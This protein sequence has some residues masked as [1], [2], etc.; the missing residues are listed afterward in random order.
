M[1]N[2]MED[3]IKGKPLDVLRSGIATALRFNAPEDVVNKLRLAHVRGVI[4][5]PIQIDEDLSEDEK[6]R[7]HSDP[8]H[9]S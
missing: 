4:G 3:V 1:I 9:N 7:P 8:I 2:L 6:G 5:S